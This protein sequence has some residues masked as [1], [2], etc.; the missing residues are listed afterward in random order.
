RRYSYGC[1][2]RSKELDGTGVDKAIPLP[3]VAEE[4]SCRRKGEG[5]QGAIRSGR[6]EVDDRR[7]RRRRVISECYVRNRVAKRQRAPTH[8]DPVVAFV[9]GCGRCEVE[10]RVGYR[11]VG[12]ARRHLVA[13]AAQF[14]R[15]SRAIAI[16][17]ANSGVSCNVVRIVTSYARQHR[18]LRVEGHRGGV[19]GGARVAT[20]TDVPVTGGNAGTG[21]TRDDHAAPV[22]RR[23][24]SLWLAYRLC[25]GERV[26]EL[27]HV[28]LVDESG[29]EAADTDVECPVLPDHV[30]IQHRER[31]CSACPVG[32]SGA[33]KVTWGAGDRRGE[34]SYK[35]RAVLDADYSGGLRQRCC[36]AVCS[37]GWAGG[38]SQGSPKGIEQGSR[39]GG[40]VVVD[41]RVVYDVGVQGVEEGY[42]SAIPAS[43]V[44]GDDVVGDGDSPPI[45]RGGGEGDDI[46]AVDVLQAQTATAAG[47]GGVAHDQVGIDGQTWANAVTGPNSARSNHAICIGC[48]RA[49]RIGI[50][51]THDEDASAVG[52]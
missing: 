17:A 40:R 42:S 21:A 44:V 11:G 32:G 41:H 15:D 1:G 37:A 3:R 10:D 50:R 47:V 45:C 4:V 25:C 49:G 23:G 9:D 52:C 36:A 8:V 38:A 18:E 43:Y 24:I 6:Y 34:I 29:G 2:R 26:V 35:N 28:F 20:D 51:R 12:D 13:R 19:V 16:L 39:R 46:R 48:S 33:S 31:G 14:R 7:G 22:G 5:A 30:V 27:D